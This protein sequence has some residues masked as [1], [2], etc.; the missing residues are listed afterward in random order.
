M[1]NIER[2]SKLTG[3]Q[4]R[5]QSSIQRTERIIDGFQNRTLPS[6]QKISVK[7]ESE[8]ATIKEEL[9]KEK[10]IPNLVLDYEKVTA[11]VNGGE[12][13]KLSEFEWEILAYFGD[14]K[15]DGQEEVP[16]SDLARHAKEMG[17]SFAS[18]L[19]TL[20]IGGIKKK[21]MDYPY[22]IISSQTAGGESA[23]KLNANVET[24]ENDN[25]GPGGTA[26][27]TLN[28]AR[29]D[30]S[31]LDSVIKQSEDSSLTKTNR[32]EVP[33]IIDR[34]TENLWE[35][36]TYLDKASLTESFFK[37]PDA[38]KAQVDEMVKNLVEF[39]KGSAQV[40]LPS[41]ILRETGIEEKR[42]QAVFRLRALVSLSLIDPQ[43]TIVRTIYGWGRQ[44]ND[45]IMVLGG[46]TQAK[47]ILYQSINS[48]DD[49][50]RALLLSK[51]SMSKRFEILKV[52]MD[53]VDER[54]MAFFMNTAV[55][56]YN[57]DGDAGDLEEI[58]ITT[59]ERDASLEPF[60][61][62][63]V[64]ESILQ[65]YPDGAVYIISR[66]KKAAKQADFV[67]HLQD[68]LSSHPETAQI[69]VELEYED[70]EHEIVPQSRRL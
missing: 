56:Q 12:E 24:I 30:P 11:Q 54:E 33:A 69:A 58:V 43:N 25:G 61:A 60:S 34:I 63:R 49:V 52:G 20:S 62:T 53:Q 55:F 70:E 40:P 36:L 2:L 28:E 57:R 4:A 13:R 22:L 46:G 59:M 17:A 39:K 41:E 38:F 29:T 1:E 48:L 10:P 18:R 14:R 66:L 3:R 32:V 67:G 45:L 35:S 42:D 37:N 65:H 51:I 50:S 44:I 21:F 9:E 6:L 26:A 19:V 15:R 5:I 47:D 8:I 7:I 64:V 27:E 31:D 23:Y 16:V 68:F